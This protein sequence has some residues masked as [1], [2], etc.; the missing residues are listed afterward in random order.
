VQTELRLA[1]AERGDVDAARPSHLLE[2]PRGPLEDRRRAGDACAR[3]TRGK[4][5]VAPGFGRREPL[6]IRQHA[7][8]RQGEWNVVVDRK[9]DRLG[10]LLRRKLHQ[11]P[12][13]ERDRGQAEHRWVPAARGNVE[14]LDQPAIHLI[15]DDDRNDQLLRAGA[16]GLRDREAGRNVV[17]GMR[18]E[19]ADIGVVEIEKTHRHAIGEGGE[20]GRCSPRRPNDGR[21]ATDREGD[22]AAGMD[23]PL[24]PRAHSAADRVD[25]QRFHALQRRGIDVIVPQRGR[26][27]G[28]PLGKRL[29]RGELRRLLRGLANNREHGGA[30]A[31]TEQSTAGDVHRAS[32]RVRT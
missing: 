30:G 18:G 6:P 10:H 28:E 22:L 19:L 7:D 25:H 27:S 3:E 16:L 31:E 32:L 24:I 20:I 12:G 9:V 23:R 1:P 14:R 17:A 5:R 15:G 13:R 29:S 8:A 26:V 4:D 21:R 2:K 11:P